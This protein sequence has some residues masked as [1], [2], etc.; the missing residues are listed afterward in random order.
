M[1]DIT[2]EDIKSFIT[3]TEDLPPADNLVGDDLLAST[4]NRVG[5]AFKCV[6]FS[7][8]KVDSITPEDVSGMV[9]KNGIEK[10]QQLLAEAGKTMCTMNNQGTLEPVVTN[11]NNIVCVNGDTTSD[12][13]TCILSIRRAELFID[14]FSLQDNIMKLNPHLAI[15][16]KNMFSVNLNLS[17]IQL[18]N[19][20]TLLTKLCDKALLNYSIMGAINA[21]VI[22]VAMALKVP[23]EYL[24]I[25]MITKTP[26]FEIVVNKIITT[27]LST[28]SFIST[29]IMFIGSTFKCIGPAG[30]RAGLDALFGPAKDTTN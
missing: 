19:I 17:E 13:I 3:N 16:M 28:D 11:T 2:L 26:M 6:N 21:I 25:D 5:N 8:A 30:L 9:E 15:L 27:N 14:I 18:L 10:T 22:G 24:N 7:N 4:T 20:R 1:S 12:N 29:V 23:E